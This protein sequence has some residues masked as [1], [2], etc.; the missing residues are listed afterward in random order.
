MKKRSLLVAG[1]TFLLLLFLTSCQIPKIADLFWHSAATK[2]VVS[3]EVVYVREADPD[4]PPVYEHR[5]TV[6]DVG[7]LV[8][9]IIDLTII[10]SVPAEEGYMGVREQALMFRF[11]YQCGCWELF[12]AAGKNVY[13]G[14]DCGVQINPEV[15]MLPKC[16]RKIFDAEEFEQLVEKYNKSGIGVD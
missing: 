2:N 12:D 11:E 15:S 9:D 8:D 10:K 7:S 14:E 4:A 16:G 5:Q 13:I 1:V 6:E 3:A